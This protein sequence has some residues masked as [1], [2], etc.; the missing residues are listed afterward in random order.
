M[1]TGK[2]VRMSERRDIGHETSGRN[3]DP[4]SSS[5]GSVLSLSLMNSDGVKYTKKREGGSSRGQGGG[6]SRQI[7]KECARRRCRLGLGRRR[8]DM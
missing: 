1:E 6:L 8:L 2:S 5:T 7:L 3:L 4:D